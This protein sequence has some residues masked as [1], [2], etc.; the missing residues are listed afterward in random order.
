MWSRS[1]PGLRW[2]WAIWECPDRRP[3]SLVFWGKSQ[4]WTGTAGFGLVQTGSQ[5]VWDRTSPTLGQPSCCTPGTLS[6]MSQCWS[7]RPKHDSQL[8]PVAMAHHHQ[9]WLTM[10][11]VQNLGNPGL[12]TA[13]A[14]ASYSTSSAGPV[15]KAP[16]KKLCGFLLL[17]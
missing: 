15:T 3:S 6:S 8:S 17:S 11:R 16:M 5:S 7:C 12:T 10:N 4:T 13:I 9:S 2:S 14:P 1:R